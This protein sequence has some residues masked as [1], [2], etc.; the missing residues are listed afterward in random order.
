MQ[1][2]VNCSKPWHHNKSSVTLST[3]LNTNDM[4]INV[5]YSFFVDCSSVQFHISSSAISDNYVML[6]STY[7]IL[8]PWEILIINKLDQINKKIN[9]WKQKIRRINTH[10]DYCQTLTDGKPNINVHHSSI[11]AVDMYVKSSS[12]VFWLLLKCS[13]MQ[14]VDL[15][16][17]HSFQYLWLG[18]ILRILKSEILRLLPL[19]V[20]TVFVS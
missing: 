3:L 2:S 6:F 20:T 19:T 15:C 14:S 11:K 16:S 12:T 7:E 10:P 1:C 17:V 4:T 9:K 13:I 18:G 5:T 8:C